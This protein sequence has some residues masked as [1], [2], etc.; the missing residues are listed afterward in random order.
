MYFILRLKYFVNKSEI[1]YKIF[2]MRAI[3]SDGL[4][5]VRYR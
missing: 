5:H 4:R 3:V 1:D 2:I